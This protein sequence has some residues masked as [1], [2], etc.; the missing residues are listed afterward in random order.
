VLAALDLFITSDT[1]PMHLASAVSTPLVALFGPAD[2]R[3]AGPR[4]ATERVLRVDLPCSPCGSGPAPPERRRT[5]CPIAW[6]AF[7]LRRRS[8]RVGACLA[9]RPA[10]RRAASDR[11]PRRSPAGRRKAAM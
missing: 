7:R 11:W 3:A 2:P 1:G 9:W 4:A 8:G 5:T 6:T 10:R